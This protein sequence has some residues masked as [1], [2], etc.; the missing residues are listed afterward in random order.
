M[1][2]LFE[3]LKLENQKE[4]LI[5]NEPEGFAEQL[6]NLVDID[7]YQSLIQVNKME[8]ALV[9]VNTIKELEGQ[10]QTL[11]PKLKDD[12]VLWVAHPRK[13]S[14]KL[15]TDITDDYDW[16]PLVKNRY[17]QVKILKINPDWEAVRFRRAEYIK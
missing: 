15:T 3:K 12:V 6:A 7:I 2:T 17:E 14:E 4:I 11:H 13:K 10:M 16:A 8:F 9:F 5:L 1:K